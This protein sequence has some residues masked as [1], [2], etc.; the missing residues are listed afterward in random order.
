MS[1]IR[2]F[3]LRIGVSILPVPSTSRITSGLGGIAGVRTCL[4][5]P[6]EPPGSTASVNSAGVTQGSGTT[7]DGTPDMAAEPEPTAEPG[8]MP[9]AKR[10]RASAGTRSRARVLRRAEDRGRGNRPVRDRD[11]CVR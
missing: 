7:A 3:T 2:S 4:A 8:A 10:S 9:V 5:T 11:R 6:V 1:G